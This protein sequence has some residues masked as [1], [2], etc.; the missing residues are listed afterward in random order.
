[1]VNVSWVV[2]EGCC[3]LLKS[4]NGRL[5]DTAD[6]GLT[7]WMLC[8]RKKLYESEKA[9]PSEESHADDSRRFL[10]VCRLLGKTNISLAETNRRPPRIRRE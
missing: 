2:S 6:K 9:A 10:C 5:L 3:G 8:V 4:N 1:M 7:N